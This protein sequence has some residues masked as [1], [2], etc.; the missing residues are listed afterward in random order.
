MH[1]PPFLGCIGRDLKCKI[2]QESSKREFLTHQSHLNETHCVHCLQPFKFLLNSKRQCLDCRFYTCKSCSR[3]NKREQGWV[4][5]P[6]RLS[7]YG[8]LVLGCW[9]GEFLQP[10]P[11]A[12]FVIVESFK[13]EGTFEGHLVQLPCDEWGQLRAGLCVLCL[14]LIP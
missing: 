11:R 4:C 14:L 7:R 9:G 10:Q 6:C 5:D 2:D 13:S 12:Q 3:Y 8:H 1:A